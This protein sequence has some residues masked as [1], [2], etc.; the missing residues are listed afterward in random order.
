MAEEHKCLLTIPR[1][2]EE[3][4]TIKQDMVLLLPVVIPKKMM[5]LD[6]FK[7]LSE[8]MYILPEKIWHLTKELRKD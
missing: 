1:C 5:L 4:H 7:E 2:H 6:D 8:E 3:R